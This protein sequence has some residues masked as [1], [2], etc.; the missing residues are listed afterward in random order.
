MKKLVALLLAAI[1]VLSMAAIASADEEGKVLNIYC[2]N[3]EF[4]TRVEK[5]YTFP[6]GITVNWVIT[7]SDNGA[8]QIALDAALKEQ[9][10]ADADKKVDMFLVEADYAVKYVD[11]AFTLD[12]IADL[13]LTEADIADMYQ[14]TK[15]IMTDSNGVLKGL[16]W[17]ACPGG[18]IYRRDY[19]PEVLGVS[20]PDQVQEYLSDW[21][22][23]DAVAEKAKEKG[24]FML[25]GYDDAYR[26]FSD[27]MATPWVVD[28]VIVKDP[29][30][31][32]WIEMT[33]KYTDN[34]WNNKANLWSAES[35][36]GATKDGKVFGYFGPAWF[37]DFCLAGWTLDD[38]SAPAAVGNGSWGEWGFCEGPV[39]FSWGGTWVCAA[40]GTDNLALVADLMKTMTCN[41][42]V[43]VDIVKE[44]GDF[45]NNVPAMTE[46]ADS[47]FSNAFLG[48]QNYLGL[49]L[50][51]AQNINRAQSTMYDQACSECIQNAMADYYN[52][53]VDLDTAWDNYFAAVEER[54]PNLT[55]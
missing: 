21:D 20:E 8:Y 29:A 32:A 42:D 6:E 35:G 31:E 47:D 30:I 41:K 2:W 28:E 33:K 49:M 16:S 13:G 4:K 7:P 14:Y 37:I 36:T 44:Y 17:Q 46:M 54:H 27:N 53:I 19:A 15:D 43:L 55:H 25:S 10:T 50:K 52:G 18:F 38:S 45:T 23:F 12:V 39:G 11:T 1:M 9:A 34:G 40:A 5:F 3:D 48:G 51:N 24:L 26:C 22:K